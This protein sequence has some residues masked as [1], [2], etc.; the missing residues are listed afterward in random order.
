MKRLASAELKNIR[1][2][3]IRALSLKEGDE[4]IAVRRTTGQDEILMVTKLG[5][6]IR[7][8][9][10]DVRSMGR[11]AA[12]VRGI[13]LREGDEVIGCEVVGHGKPCSPSLRTATASAPTRTSTAPRT[14]AA[15]ACATTKSPKRPVP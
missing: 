2:S 14:G 13:N 5:Q 9:E 8:S 1:N 15:S 10:Q 11:T 12:G 7:F 3:G 4:L 6:A